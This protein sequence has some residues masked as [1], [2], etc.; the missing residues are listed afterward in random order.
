VRALHL[1]SLAESLRPLSEGLSALG[2]QDFNSVRHE[3]SRQCQ[4]AKAPSNSIVP[5][6]KIRC[7]GLAQRSSTLSLLNTKSRDW[8]N[9]DR[10]IGLKPET[11]W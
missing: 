4:P 11:N 3:I 7:R 2:T 5:V 8:M 1:I 9:C 6:F 10:K